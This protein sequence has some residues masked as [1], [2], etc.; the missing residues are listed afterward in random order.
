[1]AEGG[2]GALLFFYAT[3]IASQAKPICVAENAPKE[4]RNSSDNPE[5]EE[6]RK[7]SSRVFKLLV[8]EFYSTLSNRTVA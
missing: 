8:Q 5:W 4:E 3:Y 7:G 6:N 1:L 2:H